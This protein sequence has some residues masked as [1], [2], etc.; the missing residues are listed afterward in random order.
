LTSY[1]YFSTSFMLGNI[2]TSHFPKVFSLPSSQCSDYLRTIHK[3]I[4]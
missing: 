1:V 2:T 3:K 4:F